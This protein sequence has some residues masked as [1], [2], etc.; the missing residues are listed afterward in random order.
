MDNFI[1][2]ASHVEIGDLY[3]YNMYVYMYS[4]IFIKNHLFPGEGAHVYVHM[5]DILLIETVGE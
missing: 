4:Y 1:F 3:K 2:Y 5:C